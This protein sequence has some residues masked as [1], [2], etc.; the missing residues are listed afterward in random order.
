M[1]HWFDI[2]D[3]LV[4]AGLV[5]AAALVALLV[6]GYLWRRVRD[7]VVTARRRAELRKVR[8]HVQAQ[9]QELHRLADLIIATSS[10]GAVAGFTIVR[11]IEAVFAEGQRSPAEAVEQLK[12]QAA[13]KGAN[14]VINL[15]T[16]RLP[17][18]KCVA[19]GDAVI[20]RPVE[21]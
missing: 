16:Q 14:A 18:G 9:Q 1:P 6:L 5:A 20:V 8:E 3:P 12:A 15:H 10:T 19:G 11:Q 13:R 21:P 17:S 2:Q 4:R 7:A